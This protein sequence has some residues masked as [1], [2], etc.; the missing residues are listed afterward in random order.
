LAIISPG[1]V[2]D[3]VNAARAYKKLKIPYIADPGQQIPVLKAKELEE[4][5]DG[6]KALFV[7][8]YEFELIIKTLKHKNTETL[9]QM[10]EILVVT[11]GAEGSVIYSGGEEIKIR[12]IKPRKVV[13]PTGAG[14]AYRAGFIKGLVNGWDLKKC[15]E[16][17]SWVAKWPVEYYGT[18]EH[19]FKIS[20]F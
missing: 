15:G 16:M 18:Q 10:V 7:N 1:N 20:N 14:D 2:V 19:Y 9:K 12:A 5:I 3:M 17:A 4:L 8:D 13:D 11:Y 6:A